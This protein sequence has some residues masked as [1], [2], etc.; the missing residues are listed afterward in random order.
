MDGKECESLDFKETF[1]SVYLEEG[2]HEIEL[3]YMTPGLE[4]GVI[5]SGVCIILF[6]LS[7]WIGKRSKSE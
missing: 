5:M 3:K 6:A 4:I 1:L 7:M 2:A